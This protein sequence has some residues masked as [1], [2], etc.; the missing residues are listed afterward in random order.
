MNP[1]LFL[2]I[3]LIV[4]LAV[5]PSLII[6]VRVIKKVVERRR[7]DALNLKDVRSS[8]DIVRGLQ[9]IHSGR[10]DSYMSRFFHLKILTPNGLTMYMASSTFGWW[11]V[12]DFKEMI[13]TKKAL[14]QVFWSVAG[15]CITV[16]EAALRST[17]DGF[18]LIYLEIVISF[19]FTIDYILNFYSAEDRFS[20]FL[21]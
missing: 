21:L 16:T 5:I 18:F 8:A 7:T 9:K 11:W 12:R 4:V 14:S 13:F 6:L 20:L 3:V 17:S 2:F 19:F 1:Y 15:V 10:F